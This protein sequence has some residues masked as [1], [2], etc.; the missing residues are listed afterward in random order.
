MYYVCVVISSFQQETFWEKSKIVRTKPKADSIKREN[1]ASA[2]LFYVPNVISLLKISIP[3]VVS[4]GYL[5]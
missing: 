4:R 5:L 2:S 3:L 1:P